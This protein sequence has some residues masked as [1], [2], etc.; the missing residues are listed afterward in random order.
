MAENTKKAYQGK[1]VLVTG[2]TGFK[3]S[4]LS[5][6]LSHIGAE[7]IGYALE[8]PSEPNL[9]E[10]VDLKNK[11]THLHGDVRDGDH[12]NQAFRQYQP[13]FVFHL[14]AQSLVRLSYQEPKT[15]YETN[16]SGTVN[17]L[18][19]M[20]TVPGVRVGIIVTSDK[21]YQNI[22]CTH[23]YQETDPMGGEDPYSSSKGCAELI[24]H[25]YRKSFFNPEE[26]GKKHHVALSSV[27]A[28]NVIG[29]GDWG[30]DRI[31][32]DSILALSKGEPIVIRNSKSIR[33]WQYVLDAL[34][35]YLWLGLLMARDGKKYSDCWNFGPADE[36]IITVQ[37]LVDM[38]ISNWGRGS[39]QT[40]KSE[41]PD[42]A[43]LLKLNSQKSRTVLG[44]RP[45]YSIEENIRRTLG[46]YKSFYRHVSK[47]K[48]YD[49][50]IQEIIDYMNHMPYTETESL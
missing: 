22:E 10:A 47:S 24:T 41:H 32:T 21:C 8:P 35:G 16:I 11:I 19:A 34:S 49:L 23:G 20:R 2:H 44:W 12:L 48:L 9:F 28:G 1:R 15:T 31:L 50:S 18:E 25:A 5:L 38:V 17:I 14:A 33:P 26:F 13:E 30:K 36:S 39:Y 46:W 42:E 6:W 3:G 27:R 43:C 4:W 45:I 29:G 37:E 7:V 40:D